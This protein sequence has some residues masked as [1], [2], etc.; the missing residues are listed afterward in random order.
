MSVTPEPPAPE[1]GLNPSLRQ[2]TEQ[3]HDT[4]H[5]TPPPADSASVQHEEGRAW[6]MV[7]LVVTLACV[8]IA[9]YL[10]FF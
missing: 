7:W 8:A 5:V 6:P 9:V 3:S 4:G 1:P 2:R 10:I